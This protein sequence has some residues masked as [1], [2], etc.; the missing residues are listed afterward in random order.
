VL[1]WNEPSIKFY[2]RLGARHLADW[3]PFRLDDEALQA[4]G[5]KQ[6]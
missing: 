5:Q 3:L 2:E 1:S 4:V 6:S